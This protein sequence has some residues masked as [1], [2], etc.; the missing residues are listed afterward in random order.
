MFNVGESFGDFVTA[1]LTF[2]SDLL[3]LV[4]GALTDFINGLN[5][6]VG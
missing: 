4:F 6:N 3:N 1:L 5:V 2:I